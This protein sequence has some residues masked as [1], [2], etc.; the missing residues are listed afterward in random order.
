MEGDAVV[1]HESQGVTNLTNNSWCPFVTKPFREH[2]VTRSKKYFERCFCSFQSP[3]YNLT[4]IATNSCLRGT[5]I[6][7][8]L[9]KY[10]EWILIIVETKRTHI[11]EKFRTINKIIASKFSGKFTPHYINFPKHIKDVC[12]RLISHELKDFPL[13][14]SHFTPSRA[15]FILTFRLIAL[16][17]FRAFNNFSTL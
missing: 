13:H 9:Q 4:I 3:P 15:S 10:L 6:A 12:S 5:I 7:W 8:F 14:K 1:K 11:R 17:V 16:S 2:R